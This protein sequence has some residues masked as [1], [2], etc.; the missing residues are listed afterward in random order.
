[1]KNSYQK[2]RLLPYKMNDLFH[3]IKDVD[4]Y[5]EFLPWIIDSKTFDH[6][7]HVFTGLLVLS[8]ENMTL[9]YQS[10]V[11]WG[12][13]EKDAYVKALAIDGPFKSL[14][15][16]WCMKN[17][18]DHTELAFSVEFEFSNILYQKIFNHLFQGMAQNMM[19]AFEKR[20]A[21]TTDD[22]GSTIN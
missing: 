14:E 16:N 22:S 1:L 12:L 8:Y 6:S 5:H 4:R 11:L 7:T 9:S 13:N 19:D 18:I 20:A 2:T 10:R 3:I 17:K 21:S 15:T